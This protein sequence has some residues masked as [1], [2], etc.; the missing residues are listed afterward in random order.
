M[1]TADRVDDES[2]AVK[3]L[4]AAAAQGH[5]RAQFNLGMCV[6]WIAGTALHV[7]LLICWL[8]V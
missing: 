1:I 7:W 6:H 4:Q 2:K 8:Q 3:W 5:A